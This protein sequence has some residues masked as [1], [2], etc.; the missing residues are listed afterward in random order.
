MKQHSPPS[1]SRTGWLTAT[2]APILLGMAVGA[3][4][5][6]GWVKVE[7]FD[8]VTGGIAGLQ[9]HP[10]FTNNQPDSVTFVDTLYYSRTP[11]ADNYGSRISGYITPTETAAYV[12]FVAADDNTSLYLSTDSSP[13]NLKLVAADQGWQNSRV[14]TGPGGESSGAG[15]VD[16]VFRRGTDPGDAV[17]AGNGFQWVGPFEN[18]SDEFLHSPRT[19]LLTGPEQAW[20]T[21]DAGGN[22]VINLTANQKYY[23]EL[24]YNEGTGGE[25]TGV[26]WKKAGDPDPENGVAGTEIPSANLSMDYGTSLTFQN[27]PQSQTVNQNQPVSFTVFVVGVPGDSDQSMF[28]YEWRVNGQPVADQ[29]N[30]P[31]YSILAPVVGD[32]GKKFSVKVTTAGGITG[33][34]AEATL[35]VVSDNVPPTI[36]SILTSDTF[37]SAKITFSEAV[38]NEAVNPANYSGSGGLTVTD[39]NFAIVANDPANPEDPKN[40]SNPSNRVAVIV[41][42]SKQTEGAVYDLTLANV[43]DLTGNALAPNTAKMYANKFQA[44][45]LN[46]H[47]W[48]GGN[49][50]PNLT[51]DPLR[52]ANPTVL[53]T[54]TEAETGGYVAG[55]YVDRVSGFFIP[56]VTGNHVFLMSAD[57]DGYTYLSTDSDPAN[58]KLIAA[59]VGWQNT[60]EWT[61]PGGDTAKRRGDL[62]GGGP[63]E[64]RSDEMLTSQRAVNGTGLLAGLFDGDPA[65]E[66]NPWPTTDAAGN[67][68]ISLVAGN[69]YYME[70]WHNEGDS[71]RAELTFKV[72]GEPDPALGSASTI[73]SARIGAFVDP[74]TLPAPV[75]T[76]SVARDASGAMVITYTGTLE[77]SGSV[78]GPYAPV[79]GATGGTHTPNVQQAAQQFYRA[80]Q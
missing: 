36:A 50:I 78:S 56:A 1:T 51:A 24:L 12:F 32:S 75:P 80:S 19:N 66:P 7:N 5:Y 31:T 44:G 23:F 4:D 20:P 55:T 17:M 43:K 9:S 34:S 11:G 64:N 60:R 15:T 70:L 69:R 37:R 77:S 79:A 71:G 28:T 72:A 53:G 41:F 49:S 10:K 54:R 42:T 61:G 76:I 74:T 13:A 16:A 47:R 8:N 14:W 52:L 67:A 25:N 6:Q 63:F 3:A 26:A 18:R 35:T 21:K 62:T 57:N 30:G 73:V 59:D 33:T 38:R 39:A 40:P 45:I 46:Y 65:T 27:Q 58:R 29:P 22:A 2:L 48:E 68:V